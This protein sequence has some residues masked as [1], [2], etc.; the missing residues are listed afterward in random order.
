MLMTGPWACGAA[1]TARISLA[2]ASTALARTLAMKPVL[3][4]SMA[5][6]VTATVLATEMASK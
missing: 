5:T 6:M 3:V 1:A 4:V 2:V